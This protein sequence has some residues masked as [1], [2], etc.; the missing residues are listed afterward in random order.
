[1]AGMAT[2]IIMAGIGRGADKTGKAVMAIGNSTADGMVLR[3]DD[4]SRNKASVPRPALI[5]LPR[6]RL[7]R[8]RRHLISLQRRPPSSSTGCP[9]R[10]IRQPDIRSNDEGS[11]SGRQLNK[12]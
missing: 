1:M 9:G 3:E 5:T 11:K 10:A 4:R 6:R 7:A 12:I 8:L 2:I